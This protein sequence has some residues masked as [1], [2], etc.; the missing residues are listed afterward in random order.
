MIVLPLEIE[1]IPEQDNAPTSE[2]AGI[3][4]QA[5]AK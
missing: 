1:T 3:E 4:N 2:T 5:F